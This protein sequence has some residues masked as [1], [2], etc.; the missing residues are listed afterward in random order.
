[1]SEDNVNCDSDPTSKPIP[2]GVTESLPPWTLQAE[3]WWILPTIPLP[4]HAK[5]LPRGALDTG[6]IDK[7]QELQAT[8]Q[9]GLGTIQLIRY[10]SSPVG[11]YDELLY[12]PGQMNYKIGGSSMSGRRNSGNIPKHLAKFEFTPET[13]SDPLSPTVIS[14]YPSLSDSPT[15]DF[16]PDPIFRTRVVPSRYLPK[17]PLNLSRIPRAILDARLIQPPLT[18]PVGTEKWC[19]VNP[20][21]AGQAQVMYP[22]PGLERGRYGDGTGFPDLQP[23]SI[24]LWWPKVEIQFPLAEILDPT[25]NESKKTK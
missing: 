1:M 23:M 9:G 25:S 3:A 6:E 18:D 2:D 11:P 20:G 8:F 14:V 22:E 17:F 19:M 24:G 10:H 16:S 7:F 4:W 12:V 21:Y 5:E 13:P 15:P